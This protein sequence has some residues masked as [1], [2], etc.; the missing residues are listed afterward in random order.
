MTER[1][2]RA[3]VEDAHRPVPLATSRIDGLDRRPEVTGPGSLAVV[4]GSGVEV[5]VPVSEEVAS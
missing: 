1:A 5:L 4:P 3:P 2:D